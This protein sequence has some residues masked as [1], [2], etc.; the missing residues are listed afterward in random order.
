MTQKSGTKESGGEEKTDA[1]GFATP[2][3][4]TNL[5]QRQSVGPTPTY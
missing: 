2:V 1:V 3:Q 5:L 4:S